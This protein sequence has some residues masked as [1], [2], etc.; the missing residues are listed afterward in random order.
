[1]KMKKSKVSA[2]V[3]AVF[4]AALSISAHAA[5][6]SGSPYFTDAQ[7][8][9]TEDEALDIVSFVNA[10]LCVIDNSRYD[11]LVNQGWYNASISVDA[12]FGQ[13]GS[14]AGSATSGFWD[15]RLLSERLTQ[16]SDHVVKGF[17]TD[18]EKPS[19]R[20]H[21]H[22]II[23]E[24]PSAAKPEGVWTMKLSL[25]GEGYDASPNA[26]QETIVFVSDGLVTGVFVE[27]FELEDGVEDRG[28]VEGYF[29]TVVE[30]VTEE[31][32]FK[33]GYLRDLE[34]GNDYEYS[35][36]SNAEYYCRK[37]IT[38]SGPGEE[39][40]F[41]LDARLA[42]QSGWSYRFYTEDGQPYPPETIGR[43]PFDVFTE[44][45][46]KGWANPEGIW[47]SEA[48]LA[49]LSNGMTLTDR[50][51]NSY[52]LQMWD[53]QV[54]KTL[55]PETR[56]FEQMQ[57]TPLWIWGQLDTDLNGTGDGN[58]DQFVEVRWTGEGFEVFRFRNQDGEE[59]RTGNLPVWAN[60]FN[61]LN[62]EKGGSINDL[63]KLVTAG[64][65]IYP[66]A[67]LLDS[68]VVIE[69][70]GS[71][72][73][74][75]T[76]NRRARLTPGDLDGPVTFTC[77]NNCIT[78]KSLLDYSSSP[79]NSPFVSQKTTYELR[80]EGVFVGD[81]LLRWPADM[82]EDRVD[83]LNVWSDD[84]EYEL[85]LGREIW[86]KTLGLLDS[87]GVPVEFAEPFYVEFNVPKRLEGS[88]FPDEFGGLTTLLRV[89]G[90]HVNILGDCYDR[91]THKFP[92]DCSTADVDT[93]WSH[94]FIIPFDPNVGVVTIRDPGSEDDGKKLWVK[95]LDRDVVLS[96]VEIKEEQKADMVL[97]T[98][99]FL[100]DWISNSAFGDFSDDPSVYNP[101]NPDSAFYIGSWPTPEEWNEE[102][103]VI[104]GQVLGQ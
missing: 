51:G 70:G 6:P 24:A 32:P 40:C 10:A 95:W 92:L 39:F 13:D 87:N 89:T 12:C 11:A 23:D 60:D 75:V 65:R 56:S 63:Q 37:Q 64:D 2:A 54:F 3:S 50:A 76:L 103:R 61:E 41:S 91:R 29:R 19:E 36:A 57:G 104:H 7:S 20:V 73:K 4:A 14:S 82:P 93:G 16:N 100:D 58:H 79:S 42:L 102:R 48:R 18:P 88:S 99:E 25:P 5:P 77:S 69:V 31:F 15:V 53:F 86:N 34:P 74:P 67:P 84:N 43:S 52:T 55:D 72:D 46:A 22:M 90:A 59:F 97:G 33:S 101:A 68:G 78:P 21:V 49:S 62:G 30:N 9:Y 94:H 28:L 81:E 83:W 44:N 80:T 47:F 45:N 66:W 26:P 17:L 27:W 98:V 1:M 96:R 71:N 8:T 35:F 85:Q 38:E